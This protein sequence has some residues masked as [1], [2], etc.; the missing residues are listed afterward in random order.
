MENMIGNII[1][2][3]KI[4]DAYTIN[5]VLCEIKQFFEQLKKFEQCSEKI[6]CWL[7][8]YI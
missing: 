8:I 1:L 3:E 7:I 2:W 5:V 4:S 6:I